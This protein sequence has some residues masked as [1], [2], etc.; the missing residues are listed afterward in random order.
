MKA[1][2]A[3][4]KDTFKVGYDSFLS[5]RQESIKA[6]D[7]FHNRQ[8]TQEQL[9]IFS[10]RGAPPETFNVVKMYTRILL[11][12]YST[13]VNDLRVDPVQEDD[14]YTAAI[15]NDVLDYIF[16][17]NNFD[18]ESDKVKSDLLLTGLICAYMDVKKTGETDVFG[19][20]KYE[21]ELSHVPSLEIILDPMSRKDDYSDSRFIHR[22]KW[23]STEEV[24]ALFPRR[25]DKLN[26]YENFLSI[27]EAEFDYTYNSQ[28]N[29]QY[30]IFDNFLVVHSIIT[31]DSGKTWSIFWSDEI[32]LSKKEITYKEVKNPYRV[33]K[34]HT[35]NRTEYYGVFREIL[36][37]QDII[38]Q[39][40]AKIQLMVNT[41]KAFV[42]DDAVDDLEEFTTRFNR[43]NAVIPVKS[44]Q[45]IKIENLTREVLD[46]YTIID[47][48]IERIQRML[49]INDA[50]LGMSYASDSG[51]KVRLQQNAAMIA[52]RY[53]TSRMEQW[54][55]LLG[56]DIINL[57]KQYF[58]S[59]DVIRVSDTYSGTRWVTMNQPLLMPTGETD[60]N[61]QPIMRP[62]YEEVLD[63]ATG[64]PL[65]D[66]NGDLIVAPIPTKDTDIAFTKA[67]LS[68]DT[69]A[70]N[71]EEERNQ[72]M[73]E[74]VLNSPIGNIISTVNPAGYFKMAS[75]SVKAMN[76]KYSPEVAKILEDTGL[77]LSQ[78]MAG[79][80]Q[81]GVVPGQM[82][83]REAINQQ[84]NRPQ[85]GVE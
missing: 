68:V 67:D 48:A 80:M 59:Y 84:P 72:I 58:T 52:L 13:V 47:K 73:L 12:Y 2:I 61:G 32:I 45:G 37:V 83:P 26:A 39:A 54:Y 9:D 82:S 11:G 20:P 41:Q 64:E 65:E 50:F 36:P 7:F 33:H 21:I 14:I 23:M 17:V 46:Q 1:D 5:S 3:T 10:E 24:K 8:F 35:S 29:G 56:W 28:F 31:D 70:Y 44:L 66:E 51:K 71:D 60:E 74:Q 25:V 40:L 6:L 62:V 43:V 81:A 38:N 4:L 78:G 63:P 55:R 49:S 77:M 34:L 42:Q 53:I 16:K 19:R 85:M 75:Y 30:M 57:V 27:P 18:A 15:L 79:A 22:F 76:T 69:I